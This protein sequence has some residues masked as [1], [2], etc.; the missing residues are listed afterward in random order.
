MF[1]PVVVFLCVFN[2]VRFERCLLIL[3]SPYTDSKTVENYTEE[4]EIKTGIVL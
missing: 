3:P 2:S 4:S 1:N